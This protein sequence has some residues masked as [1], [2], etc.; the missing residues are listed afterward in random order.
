MTKSEDGDWKWDGLREQWVPAATGAGILS[1]PM[2]SGTP[3]TGAP[4]QQ[5]PNSGGFSGLIKRRNEWLP[6]ALIVTIVGLGFWMLILSESFSYMKDYS[7]EP[8]A[9]DAVSSSDYDTDN[10]GL[11][12]SEEENYTA[13]V[14]KYNDAYDVWQDDMEDHN[15]LMKEYEGK[16]IL[17]RNIGPGFIVAGL[18]C[19]TFQSK[20]FEMSNSVKLT[21]LIGTMYMVAN[22]L[23][24]DMPGVDAAVGFGFGD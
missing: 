21:L 6:K 24:Y 10:N 12:A 11:N 19:L 15:D 16:S 20:S 8:E 13:A 23:G 4:S 7:P 3:P 22:L 9:P 18:V 5:I 1:P 14:E 2:L 17:W